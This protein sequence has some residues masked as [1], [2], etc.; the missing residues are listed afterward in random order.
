MSLGDHGVL[1]FKLEVT[2]GRPS[3]AT[4]YAGVPLVLEQARVVLPS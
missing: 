4:A 3:D 1:S 2:E